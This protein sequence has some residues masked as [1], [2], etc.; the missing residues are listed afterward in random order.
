MLSNARSCSDVLLLVSIVN[1]SVYYQIVNQVRSSA[2]LNSE[3]IML[4]QLHLTKC[5]QCGT[6]PVNFFTAEQAGT[7]VANFKQL[8]SASDIFSPPAVKQ[9]LPSHREHNNFSH[10][11][12]C[13]KAS[14][15]LARQLYLVSI[16]SAFQRGN[17]QDAFTYQTNTSPIVLG[18]RAT[19]AGSSFELVST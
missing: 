7:N 10:S 15:D 16:E 6:P 1:M 8:T 12:L 5:D 3:N 2:L 18:N 19:S 9:L 4:T 17:Y 14:K 13:G 11:H